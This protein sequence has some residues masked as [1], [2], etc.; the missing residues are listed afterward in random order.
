MLVQCSFTLFN[1]LLFIFDC[2]PFAGVFSTSFAHLFTGRLTTMTPLIPGFDGPIRA[3][4]TGA[5]SGIGRA[6][7]AELVANPQ[8]ANV[9]AV[10]RQIS[11]D[12]HWAAEPKVQAFDVD[13]SAADSASGLAARIADDGPLQLVFNAAGMLHDAGLRPEK[14][15]NQLRLS[16]LQASFAINAFAPILLAQA[17]LPLL[18]SGPCVFASLSARVGSIGDN[19]MG[20]WYSY[21]AAKAAQ[22]QLLRTFAIEWR[23]L[24]AQGSCVLLHP[25]TVDT[26]LAAPFKVGVAPGKLFDSARAARQLLEL[27]AAATPERSGKFFAWDGQEIPW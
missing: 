9:V 4:V 13:L 10:S 17:L 12:A 5:S 7:V 24:N 21:R 8:C 20:G 16:A 23:R 3:L 15:I 14:S 26:P 22:N 18:R 19:Q 11:G 6:V 25:G 1:E 2:E 27:V